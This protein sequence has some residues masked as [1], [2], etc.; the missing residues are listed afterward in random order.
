[1][2]CPA[3]DGRLL[4]FPVPPELGAHAPESSDTAAIC[5]SC[6]R[7]SP[8]SDAP[9]DPSFDAIV[10]TFPSGEAGAALALA[11]GMLDS[12]AL[13]RAAIDDCC[14]Y[15]ERAGADVLL[16]LDRVA[17]AEGIDPHFDIDRRRPQL[18]DML[19]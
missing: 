18:V 4:S 15:A 12:L 7:T 19:D 8:A 2:A 11:L 3:C 1:M 9:D 16:T 13:R 17:A 5:A 6:L 10:P 14:S